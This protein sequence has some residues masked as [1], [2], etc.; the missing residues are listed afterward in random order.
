M[1]VDGG[2]AA[3]SDVPVWC[4]CGGAIWNTGPRPVFAPQ[5][6]VTNSNRV[7]GHSW[8]RPRDAF[9]SDAFAGPGMPLL[10]SGCLC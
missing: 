9:A 5:P 2:A 8:L 7:N 6:Q 3:G 4:G 1:A 10:A